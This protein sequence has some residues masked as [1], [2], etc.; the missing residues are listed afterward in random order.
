MPSWIVDDPSIVLIMLGIVVLICAVGWW[1]TRQR[2]YAIAVATTAALIALVWAL[3]TWIDTD[4][5]RIQ[6]TIGAMAADFEAHRVDQLFSHVAS[7]FAVAGLDKQAFRQYGEGIL[8]RHEIH[9]VQIWDYE[10]KNISRQDKKATVTFR[11]RARG[12]EEHEGLPFYNCLAT[13][14]L[15]PDGQWRM[16]SFQVFL[17]TV[18]PL[19]GDPLPLPGR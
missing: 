10:A 14:V 6:R 7:A 9:G 4:S 13:F 11:A 17:P 5:K 3:S 2:G 12:L 15:E 1:N 8:R 18:D 19:R 16:Q